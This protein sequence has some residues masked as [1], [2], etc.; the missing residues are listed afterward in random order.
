MSVQTRVRHND[1]RQTRQM[2]SD[3]RIT[4]T[5]INGEMEEKRKEAYAMRIAWSLSITSPIVSVIRNV[6]PH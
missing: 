2:R 1:I 4:D 6:P 5:D 3:Y